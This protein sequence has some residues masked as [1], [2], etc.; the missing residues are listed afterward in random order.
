MAQVLGERYRV[1]PVE[2]VDPLAPRDGPSIL[3]PA[4]LGG[5][6]SVLANPAMAWVLESTGRKLA[7]VRHRGVVISEDADEEAVNVEL[8]QLMSD[9][10]MLPGI[11][12]KRAA[13][14]ADAVALVNTPRG[15]ATGFL[16]SDDLLLTN[17]HVFKTLSMAQDHRVNVVFRWEEN[18]S[19]Q[20]RSAVRLP[21]DPDRF[22]VNGN[23]ELDFA[24]VAVGLLPNGKPPGTRFGKIRMKGA[25]GKLLL[26]KPVNIIQHPGGNPRKIAFRNNLLVSVDDDSRL[27]YQTDTMPGSS[28]SPVF[29]DEWQLVALHHAAEQAKDAEGKKI[30]LNGNPVTDRTPDHL[31]NW[32]ANAGIRISFLVKHLGS[33]NL[34]GDANNLLAAVFNQT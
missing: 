22:F 23:E 18:E 10:D 27:T 26:G 33:L 14:A 25:V 16:V 9:D 5:I 30:D 7:H 12:V 19:G 15:P 11:W 31:R 32:V 21:L 1:V 20:I 28:G 29:S 17:W 6:A 34:A 24:L 2:K 13:A 8:E 4:N 3:T